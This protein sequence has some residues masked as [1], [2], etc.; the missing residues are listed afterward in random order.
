MSKAYIALGSNLNHPMK[1]IQA[2]FNALEEIAA[3]NKI[4]HSPIYQSTAMGDSPQPDYLNAVA[5]LN[6]N[7]EPLQLLDSLQAIENKQGRVR[8]AERWQSRS[9]DLD[10]LLFDNEIIDHPRLTVPHYGLGQRNFVIYPLADI[11]P[12]LILPDGTHIK[13]LYKAASKTGIQQIEST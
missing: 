13:E 10:L 4:D 1:Q 7:K 12:D 6:T 2:A 11:A 9:L 5:S 3:D 8:G